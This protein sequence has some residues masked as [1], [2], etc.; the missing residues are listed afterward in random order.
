MNSIA[1]RPIILD[2]SVGT[3]SVQY[4]F[5]KSRKRRIRRKWSR[6]RNRNFRTVITHE[7]L[8]V[9]HG[10]VMHP[11]TFEL[12]KTRAETQAN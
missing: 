9:P 11:A 4:R 3:K 1:G 12:L 7:V 2:P 10:V 6:N 5:P 8:H